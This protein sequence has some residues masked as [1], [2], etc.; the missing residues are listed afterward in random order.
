[1]GKRRYGLIFAEWVNGCG[2]QANCDLTITQDV[3]VTARFQPNIEVTASGDGS[4]TIMGVAGCTAA[5]CSLSWG[6]GRRYQLQAVANENSRF[7]GYVGCPDVRG[8]FCL[9]NQ[10]TPSIRLVFEQIVVDPMLGDTEFPR[11]GRLVSTPEAEFVWL[12]GP[13]QMTLGGVREDGGVLLGVDRWVLFQTRPGPVRDL[14]RPGNEG[15]LIAARPQLDGGMVFVMRAMNLISVGGQPLNLFDEAIVSM[16]PS[17]AYEWVSVNPGPTSDIHELRTNPATGQTYLLGGLR[18]LAGPVTY[19]TTTITPIPDAGLTD[20]R[21]YVAALD[22]HGQRQWAAHRYD[23]AETGGWPLFALSSGPA[24]FGVAR[25][26]VGNPPCVP[27]WSPTM[28]E[29][30]ANLWSFYTTQGGCLRSGATPQ[31]PLPTGAIPFATLAAVSDGPGPGISMVGFATGTTRWSQTTIPSGLFYAY[32]E[33][34][35]EPT[36]HSF[37]ACANTAFTFVEAVSPTRVV[38]GGNGQCIPDVDTMPRAYGALVVLYDRQAGS[39][40]RGWHLPNSTLHSIAKL[41]DR[42]VRVLLSFTPPMRIGGVDYPMSMNR[43]RRYLLL[44]LRP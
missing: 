28:T 32:Q 33:G 40:V 12:Y 31:Q 4:G 21:L 18:S 41:N 30:A 43:P 20:T 19:G 6:P 2:T 35:T 25:N 38:L 39:V 36:V 37:A 23:T 9:V 27:V 29:P 22:R 7:V 15:E 44:T 1:M 11:D 3:T 34:A 16:A 42:E 17:G 26:S 24:V 5:P 10:Y 14:L 13:G 8:A